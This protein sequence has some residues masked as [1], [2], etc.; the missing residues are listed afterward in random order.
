MGQPSMQQGMPGMAPGPPTDY[1]EENIDHSITVPPH[2]L[3]CVT[4]H[5]PQSAQLAHATKVP[6]G[7][8]IR[9]LAPSPLEEEEVKVVQPGAAGIVR[10]KR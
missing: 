2:I 10:C 7:A 5:I 4:T 8:V 1:F 3:Q 9:P 6:L